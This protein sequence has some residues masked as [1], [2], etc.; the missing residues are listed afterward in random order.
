MKPTAII[1]IGCP[2]SGKSTFAKQLSSS[3]KQIERDLIRVQLAGSK[4]AFYTKFDRKVGEAAVSS[5]IRNDLLQ[6]VENKQNVIISDTNINKQLRHRLYQDLF[7]MGFKVRVIVFDW[8]YEELVGRNDGRT[9][10]DQVPQSVLE[11]MY[12]EFSK[13]RE[14]IAQ[15]ARVL[16]FRLHEYKG[17][18]KTVIFDIDGTVA[19]HVGIRS[20]YDLEKVLL[21]NPRSNIIDLVD[22]YALTC[23]I[24]YFS[25]RDRS[26]HADTVEWIRKFTLTEFNELRMR[27]KGDK[28]PDW[29][30]KGEM[31]IEAIS[32]NNNFYPW[33]VFDDRQQVV[34]IWDNMGIEVI[35]VQQ[36]RF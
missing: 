22:N 20:P 34:N 11:R 16:N 27:P 33:M 24:V 2:G 31:M 14:L 36:G 15:E 23:N 32:S 4:K 21:D 28:R 9:Q 26:C 35:Q 29:I 30:V 10:D 12:G 3:H 7:D 17:Q 1:T 19:S 18:P 13:Q 6:C 25:G 8:N 5:I